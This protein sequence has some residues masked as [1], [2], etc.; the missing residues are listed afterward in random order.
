MKQSIHGMQVRLDGAGSWNTTGSLLQLT[1]KSPCSP[2]SSSAGHP[3]SSG[4]TPKIHLIYTSQL[5]K[6]HGMEW[7]QAATR[8]AALLAGI[9]CHLGFSAPQ[10]LPHGWS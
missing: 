4:A 9:R 3:P 7:E 8:E 5:Q 2:G 10:E 6:S 1:Q